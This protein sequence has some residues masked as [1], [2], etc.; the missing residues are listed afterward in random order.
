VLDTGAGDSFS[1]IYG[2][3]RLAQISM[4]TRA[5]DAAGVET[6]LLP[7]TIGPFGSSLSR[8]LARFRLRAAADV[9]VRD[10]QSAKA[11]DRLGFP[12]YEVA[13]DLVFLLPAPNS[14]PPKIIDVLLN[15]SG[16]L[17][18]SST[19]G[20]SNQYQSDIRRLI[21]RLESNG[22]V[23][24][25]LPHVLENATEDN[26]LIAISALLDWRPSLDVVIPTSLESVRETIAS[27]SLVIGSRMHACLNALSMGVPAIPWAYSRKFGPLLEAVGWSHV[28]DLRFAHDPVAD[29]L[30]MMQLD[31]QLVSHASAAA[32]RGRELIEGATYNVRN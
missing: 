31:D 18:T 3:K 10:P 29:T 8:A 1:D 2:I 4:V 23:V 26:D 17:W 15:V 30:R 7:Q 32:S 9:M 5:A 21:E 27:A 16:L 19:L 25:L 13:S 22:R 14:N 12:D 20:D 24:T 28:V 11:L 6:V